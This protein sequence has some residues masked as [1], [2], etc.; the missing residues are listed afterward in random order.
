MYPAHGDDTSPNPEND[1]NRPSS[2]NKEHVA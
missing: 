1:P 2:G